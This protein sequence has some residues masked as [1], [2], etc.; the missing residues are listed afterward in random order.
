MF[1]KP[2]GKKLIRDTNLQSLNDIIWYLLDI[3]ILSDLLI[4]TFG[5]ENARMHES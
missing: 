4:W 5:R 3:C 2:A 1:A